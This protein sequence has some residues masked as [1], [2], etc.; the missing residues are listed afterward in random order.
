MEKINVLI[1][2]NSGGL[3]KFKKVEFHQL[4]MANMPQ[5]ERGQQ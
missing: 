3:E 1:P 4:I 2:S 5:L